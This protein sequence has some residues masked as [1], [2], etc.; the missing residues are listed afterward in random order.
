M[1]KLFKLKPILSVLLVA[2]ILLT[3]NSCKKDDKDELPELPPKEALLMDFSDF[4]YADI[5]GNK[6]ALATCYNFTFAVSNVV[7]WNVFATALVAIP[8]L[9]YAEAFK[10]EAVYLGENSW[11]WLY[12]ITDNQ[13]TYTAKLISKRIS[14][15]EFTLKM[16]V[17][18][19]GTGGFEDFK[20]FEGT[21][22][23][24]RTAANWTLYSSPEVTTPVMTID[25]TKDWEKNLYSIKYT[26]VQTGNNYGSYIEHGITENSPFNAYYNIS[27]AEGTVQIEWNTTTKVGHVKSQEHFGDANWHCWDGYFSDVVCE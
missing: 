19:S 24:D 14:N 15:E 11:Q 8:Y 5:P 18:K 20:W 26:N 23:Y 16:L 17:S 27:T 22:R 12:S 7:V 10:H 9:A 1:S 2:L 6:K 25:W 13:S 3:S 21:V 4:E